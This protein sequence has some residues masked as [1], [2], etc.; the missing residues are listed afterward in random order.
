MNPTKQSFYNVYSMPVV[1]KF[2]SAEGY[3]QFQQTPF[4][5]DIDLPKPAHKGRGT[6]TEKLQNGHRVQISGPL[7][8]PWYFIAA[9]RQ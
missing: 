2:L 8:M 5:I 7:L 6:F 9:K 1:R 3:S 4:E